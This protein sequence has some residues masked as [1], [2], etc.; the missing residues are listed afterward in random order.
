MHQ[1]G[2]AEADSA[3][4]EERVE[5]HRAHRAGA[6]FGDPPGRG[7]GQ[8]VGLA[9]YKILE[10]EARIEPRRLCPFFAVFERGG[11]FRDRSRRGAVCHGILA[12]GE[13]GAAG[14]IRR[15]GR[16]RVGCDDHQNPLDLPVLCPPQCQDPVRVMRGDP[17]AKKP[18]RRGDNRLAAIDPLHA[19]RDEPAAISGLPDLLLQLAENSVPLG[20]RRCCRVVGTLCLSCFRHHRTPH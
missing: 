11:R 16:A 5:R 2:L 8:L 1:M 17:I 15:S 6:G 13:I 10:G 4:K 14:E 20:L 7:M 12:A 3:I 9:D 18:R 19:D